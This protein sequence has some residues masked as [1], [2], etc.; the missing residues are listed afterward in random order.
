MAHTRK[1]AEPP[2]PAPQLTH[3]TA[4][5][6]VPVLGESVWESIKAWVRREIDLH[7]AGVSRGDREKQNP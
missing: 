6:A 2:E 4:E 5:H 3:P 1:P 7:S